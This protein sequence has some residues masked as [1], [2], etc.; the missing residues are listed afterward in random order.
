MYAGGD[1]DGGPGRVSRSASL[2]APWRALPLRR[3]LTIMATARVTIARRSTRPRTAMRRFM[4]RRRSMGL[5]TM[6]MAATAMA[7][8]AMASATPTRV[9]AGAA[10]ATR[11]DLTGS[12]SFSRAG[13]K[14][15]LFY[16]D[17]Y[18]TNASATG[19]VTA[20]ITV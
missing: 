17:R 11:I 19:S 15:R 5:A 1:A 14:A 12:R 4:L 9:M 16:A 6:A 20:A 10:R 13:R 18:D 3:S 8:M 7:A 2:P